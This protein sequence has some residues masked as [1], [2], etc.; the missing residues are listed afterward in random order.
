MGDGIVL[1][2]NQT[3]VT[4]GGVVGMVCFGDKSLVRLEYQMNFPSS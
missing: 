4:V 1:V 3:K 2:I